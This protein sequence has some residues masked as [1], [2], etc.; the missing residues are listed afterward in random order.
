MKTRPRNKRWTDE[1]YDYMLKAL[2]TRSVKHVAR[3]LNRS[4]QSVLQK[5]N[6]SGYSIKDY[7]PHV[8]ATEL[9]EIVKKKPQTVAYW[10]RNKGLPAKKQGTFWRIPI[11]SFWEWAKENPDFIDV[12]M[13]EENILLPE[14]SWVKEK[15]LN[16][17]PLAIKTWTDNEA[18]LLKNLLLRTRLTLKEIAKE[19]NRTEASVRKKSYSIGMG[20]YVKGR[21]TGFYSKTEEDYIIKS[22]KEGKTIEEIAKTLERS[23]RGLIKKIKKLKNK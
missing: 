12:S 1:E 5:F 16:K 19:L 13:I 22:F 2:E 8:T 7:S 23:E 11:D 17:E 3:R 14:P 9:A 10:I 21:S 6:D 15:R 4:Y 18:D 20:D